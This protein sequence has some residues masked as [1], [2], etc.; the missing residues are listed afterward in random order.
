MK[1]FI[2]LLGAIAAAPLIGAPSDANFSATVGR[3][4]AQFPFQVRVLVGADMGAAALCPL[5]V[6]EVRG[7]QASFVSGNVYLIEGSFYAPVSAELVAIQPDGTVAKQVAVQ[8]GRRDFAV[9]VKLNGTGPL[10]IVCRS[11][12]GAM[13]YGGLRVSSAVP[14][15]WHRIYAGRGVY[16][17]TRQVE[18]A[19]VSSSGGL[20]WSWLNGPESEA[21]LIRD[22]GAPRPIGNA[23]AYFGGSGSPIVGAST[24][25]IV[26]PSKGK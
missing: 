11:P 1:P 21:D 7:Q 16:Y 13:S 19:Y 15:W 14:A 18:L 12:G 22:G 26:V 8:S 2:L 24:S 3:L 17:D 4:E 5:K 20:S 25:A 9:T 23:A 6:T 10:R